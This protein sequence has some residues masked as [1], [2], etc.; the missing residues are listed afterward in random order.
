M[1]EYA[2]LLLLV[3][4]VAVVAVQIIGQSVC[5][6]FSEAYSGFG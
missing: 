3:L 2:L 5:G 4:V 6:R 1:V